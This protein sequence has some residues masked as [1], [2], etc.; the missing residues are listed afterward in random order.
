MSVVPVKNLFASRSSLIASADVGV[1]TTQ[2][3]HALFARFMAS[4]SSSSLA[5]AFSFLQ[6]FG[7]PNICFTTLA[8]VRPRTGLNRIYGG[9]KGYGASVMSEEKKR[10]M[11][12]QMLEDRKMVE[13]LS[14]EQS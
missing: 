1:A 10:E 14:K 7:R 3:L 9:I 6:R 12:R 5:S 11:M 2:F 8:V 4:I 13:Q